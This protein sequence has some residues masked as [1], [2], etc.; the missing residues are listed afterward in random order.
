MNYLDILLLIP[1]I[2]FAFKGFKNGLVMEII[3]LVSLVAGIYLAINFSHFA[4]KIFNLN[5]AHSEV[6]AF[7]LTFF[8]VVI[9]VYILGRTLEN[10]LKKAALETLN[11]LAG[12]LLG[13]TKTILVCSVIVFLWNKLDLHEKVI[14]TQTRDSS[15][16]FRPLEKTA[17]YIFPHLTKWIKL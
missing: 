13:V 12:M 3:S 17:T 8:A 16:L 15:L 5:G 6:I 2:W 10:L 11:R 7:T 14:K 1:M 4:V 9:G